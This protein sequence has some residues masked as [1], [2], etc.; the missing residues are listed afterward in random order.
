MRQQHN[1]I[2][3]VIYDA[4]AT[5]DNLRSEV[6]VSEY[7]KIINTYC[8]SYINLIFVIKT[9][10]KDAN[11]NAEIRSRYVEHWQLARTEQNNQTI[12]DKEILPISVIEYFKQR[13]DNEQRVHSEVELL[14][15]ISI[16]VMY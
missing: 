14:I 5:I 6:E 13:A 8:C 9:F 12:H 16:N 15:N 10:F 3:S 1:H 7:L 2:K 11:L 4:N